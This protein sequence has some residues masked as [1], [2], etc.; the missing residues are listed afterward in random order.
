M[1]DN[2]HLK[3]ASLSLHRSDRV[4][5]LHFPEDIYFEVEPVLRESWPPGIKSEG[6]YFGSYEYVLKGN[7][8]GSF[9]QTK[10]VHSRK[11]LCAILQF[12]YNRGWVLLAA[13][14]LSERLNSK[15]SMIFKKA[16]GDAETMAPARIMGVQFYHRRKIFLH[17][18]AS[19]SSSSTSPFSLSGKDEQNLLPVAALRDMLKDL[20]FL[21]HQGWSHDAYEFALKGSPW[22]SS[23]DKSM[24]VREMMLGLVEIMHHHGWE[25]YGAIAQRSETDDGQR[26]DSWYFLKKQQQHS[27]PVSQDT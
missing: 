3:Y 13:V 17:S 9:G 21:E 14:D 10:S 5:F 11:L 24:K 7:P 23:G 6:H 12:L 16:A 1:M 2:L 19:S 20:D 4:R 8:W 18:S 15:D 25:S 22:R 27:Q 26:C